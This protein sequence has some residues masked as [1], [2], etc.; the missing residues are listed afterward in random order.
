[1]R[2][3]LII[4]A[5][6]MAIML[7]AHATRVPDN[8]RKFVMEEYPE[9]EFR[10][11]GVVILPDGTVYLPLIPSKFNDSEPV[12]IKY[13]IPAGKNL[14]MKPDAIVLSNDYVLLKLLKN[15]KVRILL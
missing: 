5:L 11:D 14:A 7:P 4:L 6:F 15:E 13:T 9:T 8:V 2:K 12:D 10:F 3:L 1:M